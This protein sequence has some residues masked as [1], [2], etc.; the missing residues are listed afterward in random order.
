MSVVPNPVETQPGFSILKSKIQR[1]RS[2]IAI[3]SAVKL[4][5]DDRVKECSSDDPAYIGRYLQCSAQD[6]GGL[7]GHLTKQLRRLEESV[8]GQA[9]FKFADLAERFNQGDRQQEFNAIADA[10][11]AAQQE[12]ER[13]SR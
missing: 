5:I 9:F 3:V 12:R 11:Y 6:L 7:L 10:E 2:W 1:L 4:E 13:L 8:N